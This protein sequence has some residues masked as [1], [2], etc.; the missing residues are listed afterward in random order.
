MKVM[1]MKKSIDLGLLS[2]RRQH[3]I[4][5]TIVIGVFGMIPTLRRFF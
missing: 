3:L 2:D 4:L 5:M 1:K